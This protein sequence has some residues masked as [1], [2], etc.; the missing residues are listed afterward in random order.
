[1]VKMQMGDFYFSLSRDWRQVGNSLI[2]G[3]IFVDGELM[4]DAEIIKLLSKNKHDSVEFKHTILSFNGFFAIILNYH[5]ACILIVDLVR[6]IPIFYNWNDK[7][8][9]YYISDKINKDEYFLNNLNCDL[10]RQFEG[11]LFVFGTHTLLVNFFQVMAGEM[12][13]LQKGISIN[14]IYFQFM[15]KSTTDRFEYHFEEL[16]KLYFNSISKLIRYANGRQIV[17]PLSGGHDSRMIAY[18]LV[19]SGYKNLLAFS[20]GKAGDNECLTAKKVADILNIKW[21]FIEYKKKGMRELFKR[22][23]DEFFEFASDFASLPHIQDWYAVYKL[24]ELGVLS[25]GALFVPGHTGDF[26]TGAHLLDKYRN[27]KNIKFDKRSL[28]I[29]IMNKHCQLLN[30]NKRIFKENHKCTYDLVSNIVDSA[31]DRNNNINNA[32]LFEM[33]NWRERQAKY[34]VNSCRTYEFYKYDWYMPLWDSELVHYWLNVPLQERLNRKM[35]RRFVNDFFSDELKEI[36]YISPVNSGRK[37]ISNTLLRYFYMFLHAYSGH[38]AF[39]YFSKASFYANLMKR[40]SSSINSL[41]NYTYMKKILVWKKN[42][43]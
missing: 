13:I 3:S 19:K 35:Y 24:R 31:M 40:Q 1:M 2:I 26:L 11:S 15:I 28:I 5:D 18:L 14:K 16:Q 8:K 10:V 22:D 43:E 42:N 4:A 17:L 30:F 21:I 6:S 29:D 9:R 7:D 32:Q 12:T 38:Y 34:I 36:P 37:V 23:S 27:K 33:F 39:N 41:T 25:E 20:Y